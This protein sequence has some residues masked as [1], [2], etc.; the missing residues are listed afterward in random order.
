MDRAASEGQKRPSYCY[1][2]QQYTHHRSAYGV[3]RMGSRKPFI[4]VSVSPTQLCTFPSALSGGTPTCHGAQTNFQERY[5]LKTCE[6]GKWSLVMKCCIW[7]Y[8]PVM[9]QFLNHRI[10]ISLTWKGNIRATQ[11]ID[12]LPPGNNW[13]QQI[14]HSVCNQC[15]LGR[16]GLF[17]AK[18]QC[19]LQSTGLPIWLLLIS[20]H[21]YLESHVGCTN[22]ITRS[23]IMW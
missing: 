11:G 6:R 14:Q 23:C 9:Q 5:I 2:P 13:K 8:D 12:C 7:F 21:Q 18:M 20:W 16:F 10:E 4:G 1:S 15:W 17:P 3:L 19:A 22:Y